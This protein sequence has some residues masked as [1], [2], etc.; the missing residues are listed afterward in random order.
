V[1]CNITVRLNCYRG[2]LNKVDHA[3]ILQDSWLLAHQQLVTMFKYW[4]LTF[5]KKEK[6]FT[7]QCFSI[8][9]FTYKT[10]ETIFVWLK[11]LFFHLPPISSLTFMFF[12]SIIQSYGNLWGNTGF[13]KW[14]QKVTSVDWLCS[15]WFF[16]LGGGRGVSFHGNNIMNDD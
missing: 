14:V 8:Q 5:F 11:L 4:L 1:T 9:N 15:S 3:I 16:F 10:L 12:A 6:C 7:R 13:L 2:H